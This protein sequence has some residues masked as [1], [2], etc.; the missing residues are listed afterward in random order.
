MKDA[1]AIL[2]P[3]MIFLVLA[4]W[5]EGVK[6]GRQQCPEAPVSV[7]MR[8]QY[9]TCLYDWTPMN[10]RPLMKRTPT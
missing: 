6:Y 3:V 4:A 10:N 8:G 9:M 1:L 7:T 5:A 2:V